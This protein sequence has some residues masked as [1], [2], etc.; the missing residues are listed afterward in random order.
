M[1]NVE[2]T[3]ATRGNL[4]AAFAGESQANRSYLA[5]A[6][7]AEEEG[8]PLVAKRFRV[9][10]ESETIHAL[11]H[12]QTMGGVGTTAE[13]LRAAVSGENYEHTA[14]YPDFIEQAEKDGEGKAK[15]SFRRANEAEKVHEKMFAE[16]LA[17]PANV[18]DKKYFICRE[19]GMT[20]ADAAPEKCVVCAVPGGQITEV[21]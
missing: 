17:D 1:S 12:L 20:Y 14:M 15:D 9:A 4:K 16:A 7:R 3:T 6:K 21:V 18:P 10:A 2:T 5:F 19:C 13:N 8:L 11:K